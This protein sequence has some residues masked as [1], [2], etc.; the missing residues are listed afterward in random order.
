VVCQSAE[1]AVAHGNAG[2]EAGRVLHGVPGHLVRRLQPAQSPN[3]KSEE[4]E[5]M[6]L[7]HKDNSR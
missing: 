7:L 5:A 3:G 6:A 2:A 4:R 1:L